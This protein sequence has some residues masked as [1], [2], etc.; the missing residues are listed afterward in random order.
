MSINNLLEEMP[1]LHVWNGKKQ[2]GGFS[3]DHLHRLFDL[4]SRQR[5]QY[6]SLSCIETGAGL[7]TLALLAAEPD[8]LISICTAPDLYARIEDCAARYGFDCSSWQYFNKR[9]EETL[10]LLALSSP[11][12]SAN[13]C[14][15]DGAHGYPA[16]FV[17]FCYMNMML[18][19]NGL[20][21]VDDLPLL[22]PRELFLLLKEQP[23]W[24]MELFLGKMAV[25]RKKLDTP[26]MPD[27]GG[28]P[29]V[30]VHSLDPHKF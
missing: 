3:R 15:I 12:A 22:P 5:E 23:G 19:Q 17:D 7:S 28:Q 4:A 6:G 29:Y 21:I 9:S 24:K 25:F 26:F 20:L 8:K 18:R 14:L 27:F 13:L 1:K 2:T 30:R 10:P 11:P 16:P